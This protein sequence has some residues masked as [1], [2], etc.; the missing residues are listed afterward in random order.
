MTTPGRRYR[1]DRYNEIAAAAEA[2]GFARSV[3][4]LLEARGVPVSDEIRETILA[5]TDLDQLRIW[6]RRAV[7]ATT[8]EGV[9]LSQTNEQA[10][11]ARQETPLH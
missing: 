4:D 11:A 9:I 7:T 8:A 3:V 2:R 10:V 5:C 6:V 1:T